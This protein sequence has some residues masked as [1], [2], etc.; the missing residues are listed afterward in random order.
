MK[1]NKIASDIKAFIFSID[2]QNNNFIIA[3]HNNMCLVL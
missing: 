3:N 1:K 2:K